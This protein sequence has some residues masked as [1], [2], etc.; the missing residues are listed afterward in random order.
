MTTRCHTRCHSKF[1][2]HKN[3]LW[4]LTRDPTCLFSATFKCLSSTI[5]NP[6]RLHDVGENC[7]NSKLNV[8]FTKKLY[9]SFNL[10][11]VVYDLIV[12][13]ALESVT[14]SMDWCMAFIWVPFFSKKNQTEAALYLNYAFVW[15][16]LFVFAVWNYCGILGDHEQF[17]VNVSGQYMSSKKF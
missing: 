3:E 16:K 12:V 7:R 4:K 5:T 14:E 1:R 17:E 10:L 2:A 9:K 13:L 15:H 6:Q 11:Y 8:V